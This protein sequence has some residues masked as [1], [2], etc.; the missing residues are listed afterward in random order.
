MVLDSLLLQVYAPARK[1]PNGTHVHKL[2]IQV[3]TCLLVSIS[4]MK[5]KD[6]D[7]PTIPYW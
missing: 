3:F 7:E 4:S 2:G 1:Y 6:V 5:T